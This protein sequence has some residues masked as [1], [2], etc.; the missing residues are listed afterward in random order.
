M[1][2]VFVLLFVA[3]TVVLFIGGERQQDWFCFA[4]PEAVMRTSRKECRTSR[5][6]CRT[7]RKECRTSR[8]CGRRSTLMRL[9]AR[10]TYSTTSSRNSSI[11]QTSTGSETFRS[12]RFAKLYN[13]LHINQIYMS[14]VRG[15]KTLAAINNSWRTPAGEC[16]IGPFPL[17]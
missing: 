3:V 4:L 14:N 17:V 5:K 8:P 13:N 6:E 9:R 10:K 15:A 2:V 12:L 11:S 1:L 7:S 16:E